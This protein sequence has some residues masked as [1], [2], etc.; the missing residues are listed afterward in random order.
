MERKTENWPIDIKRPLSC[1]C[2]RSKIVGRIFYNITHWLEVC[3]FLLESKAAGQHLSRLLWAKIASFANAG[4]CSVSCG[5]RAGSASPFLI[6][7][8]CKNA[9]KRLTQK[10]M[11]RTT[12]FWQQF[13]GWPLFIIKPKSSCENPSILVVQ[14]QKAFLVETFSGIKP[15]S[16]LVSQGAWKE[17]T[18]MLF[19]LFLEKIKNRTKNCN[20]KVEW[21]D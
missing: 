18:E 19:F 7:E 15:V 5:S 12:T 2:A 16:M 6:R 4:A 9:M 21:T 3:C 8:V 13:E 1:F 10:E 20:F 14:A 17:M 11:S